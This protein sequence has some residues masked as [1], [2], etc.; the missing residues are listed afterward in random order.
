MSREREIRPSAVDP[1]T[2]KIFAGVAPGLYAGGKT[3]EY[4]DGEVMLESGAARDRLLVLVAGNAEIRER[5]VHIAARG[6]GHLL[7]ELAFIDGNPRAA[8]VIAHGPALTFELAA[9]Q[10][11]AL[12]EDAAFLR[13]LAADLCWK[14][15]TATEERAWRYRSEE[16]LFGEFRAHA[17]KELLQELL[18]SGDLGQPRRAEV[19]TM[20][21]DIRGFT[22]TSMHVDPQ[23]LA[24]ELSGFLDVAIGVVHEHGGMIDKFIG[25]AVMA[26]WGYSPKDDDPQ[27]AVAAA[28]DLVRRSSGLTLDGKPLRV[29]VGL[30]SG[31]ATLGVIGGPGKRQFTAIGACVNVAARLETETKRLGA[32]ICVGPA[33]A[34]RLPTEW[35]ERLSDPIERDIRGVGAIGV[36][37]LE[38][39]E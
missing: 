28:I 33:L 23:R 11:L 21:T 27:N 6:P 32:P 31:E 7:G 38:P 3:C 34:A 36:R 9:D 19:V 17:S 30:E 4:R 18:R 12:L 26:I 15:R 16:T 39:K 10:V 24:A 8:S 14:L 5:G 2:L 35:R 37:L 13:N 22:A 25:D 20:F 1:R 29:G